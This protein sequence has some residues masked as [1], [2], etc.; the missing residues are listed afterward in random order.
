MKNRAEEFLIKKHAVKNTN[1]ISSVI[2]DL[3]ILIIGYA[4]VIE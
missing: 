2:K 1:F 3:I 4:K